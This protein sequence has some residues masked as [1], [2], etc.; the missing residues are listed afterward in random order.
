MVIK[1]PC[2]K[3]CTIERRSGLCYGCARSME[4]IREWGRMTDEQRDQVQSE[5]EE[6]LLVHFGVSRVRKSL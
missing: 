4:E 6:R 5:I 2:I 1:S 3:V